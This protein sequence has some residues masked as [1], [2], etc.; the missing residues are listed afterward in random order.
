MTKYRVQV[1]YQVYHV[2]WVDVEAANEVEA[3]S[4]A[5][6]IAGDQPLDYEPDQYDEGSCLET[7]DC[8]GIEL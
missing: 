4:Q 2:T 6:T 5:L 3:R 7:L 1:G 8:K